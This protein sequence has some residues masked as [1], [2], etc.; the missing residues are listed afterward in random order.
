M[1]CL[2]VVGT[3]VRILFEFNDRSPCG[4]AIARLKRGDVVIVIREHVH[5][6]G[7]TTNYGLVMTAHGFGWIWFH[8]DCDTV[9]ET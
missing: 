1:P 5:D 7:L 9:I 8:P 6:D 3:E 4:G 2:L